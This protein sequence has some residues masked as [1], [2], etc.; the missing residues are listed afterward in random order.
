MK[1]LFVKDF[2]VLMKAMK[3]ALV[4]ILLFSFMDNM[5]TFVIFYGS[6]LAVSSFAYDEKN[7]W[8]EMAAM[9]PYSDRE[10]V[11]EKYIFGY[12][13]TLIG[14]AVSCGAGFITG[15]DGDEFL[16]CLTGFLAVLIMLPINLTLIYKFGVEKTRIVYLI[17]IGATTALIVLLSDLFLKTGANFFGTFDFAL[18]ALALVAI[19]F[20]I[21][22]IFLSVKFYRKKKF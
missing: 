18:P 19:L 16:F 4:A 14:F 22:G 15:M 10:M 5:R 21:A 2:R 1:G 9:L 20:N 13:G 7:K 8:N 12:V 6:L 3:F 11:L 17:F